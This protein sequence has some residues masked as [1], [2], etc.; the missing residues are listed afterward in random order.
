MRTIVLI[1]AATALG[2]CGLNSVKPDDAVEV[3]TAQQPSQSQK[4]VSASA[5]GKQD[6]DRLEVG[7]GYNAM[8]GGNLYANYNA[9]FFGNS[10]AKINASLAFSDKS[11]SGQQLFDLAE[12]PFSVGYSASFR[13]YKIIPSDSS[14]QN[15]QFSFTSIGAM[16]LTNKSSLVSTFGVEYIQSKTG[17]AGAT[18]SQIM[19]PL[20]LTYRL[21]ER[22]HPQIPAGFGYFLKSNVEISALGEKYI[23]GYVRGQLDIPLHDSIPIPELALSFKAYAGSETSLNNRAV[24]V[25]K[26]FFLEN[27]PV[28]GYAANAFG[29]NKNGAPIGGSTIATGSVELWTP[30]FHDDLRLYTFF[31]A[32]LIKG[33]SVQSNLKKSVGAGVAWA[34]PIGVISIS[35][36]QA[37]ENTGHKQALGINL[38]FNY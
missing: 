24:P 4:T 14:T 2:G 9:H 27:A 17:M 33:D 19:T 31:D 16:A 15:R 37:L 18:G 30:F 23:K 38:G 22:V 29:Y 13:D 6:R 5:S 32:G 25:V 21:D 8:R 11:I 10:A 7:L 20:T 3:R 12:S 26:R 36:G 34:S 1:F 28:R 35:Y